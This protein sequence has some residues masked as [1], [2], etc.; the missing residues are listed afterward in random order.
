MVPPFFVFLPPSPL[1]LLVIA[2]GLFTGSVHELEEYTDNEHFLWQLDC[3]DPEGNNFWSL[4]NAVFGWRNE[5]TQGTLSAYIMYWLFV[6]VALLLLR[7]KW[8]REA[9]RDA[10]LEQQEAPALSLA[11]V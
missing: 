1:L 11:N 5:A 10:R 2:A 8:R 4:L 3:C 9:E 6:V 7:L